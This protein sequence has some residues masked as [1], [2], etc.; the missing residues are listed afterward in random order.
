MITSSS[1]PWATPFSN[2]DHFPSAFPH[3]IFVVSSFAPWGLVAFYLSHQTVLG[4]SI[5]KII[6]LEHSPGHKFPHTGASNICWALSWWQWNSTSKEQSDTSWLSRQFLLHWKKHWVSTPHPL[7]FTPSIYWSET[8]QIA[9]Y[10]LGTLQAYRY[11]TWLSKDQK[12]CQHPA[13][14]IS[15]TAILQKLLQG[16]LKLKCWTTNLNFKTRVA[17]NIISILVAF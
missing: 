15:G 12:L 1:C 17:E 9:S 7:V 11:S 14:P 10:M 3:R 4:L 16:N 6:W 13:L 8:L 2:W 5:A